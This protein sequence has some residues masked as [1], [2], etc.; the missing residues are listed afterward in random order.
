MEFMRKETSIITLVSGLLIM[1]PIGKLL[2]PL[3]LILPGLSVYI[4]VRDKVSIVELLG[5][6]ITLSILIFPVATVLAY[7]FH[8]PTSIFLGIF[9]IV[10]SIVLRKKNEKVS[11]T[12]EDEDKRVIAIAIFVALFVLFPLLSTF[13]IGE[14]GLVVSPT[15]SGDL[16]YHLSIIK[17][18][19]TST[20]IPP[21]DPYLPGHFMPY[22]W[23]MHILMGETCE[24]T[25]ISP[26]S[27]LKIVFPLLASA[28]FLNIFILTEYIFD[29]RAA[30]AS[31]VLYMFTGGFSWAYILWLHFSGSEINLFRVLIYSWSPEMLK[32][33][34]TMLFY[35]LPQTQSFALVIMIFAIYL[36]IYSIIE[37]SDKIAILA[38][39]AIGV[40]SHYHLISAFPIFLIVGSFALYKIREEGVFKV[41]TI[42]IGTAL[43]ITSFQIFAVSSGA[44]SQISIDHHPGILY[45]AVVSMGFLIPFGVIGAVKSIKVTKAR[46]ILLFAIILIIILNVLTMPLTQNTY[47]F[48]VYLTI[49]TSIFSGYFVS[50]YWDYS[51]RIRLIITLCILLLLPSTM[52]LGAYYSE[53]SYVHAD[54]NELLAMEWIKKNTSVDDI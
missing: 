19:M 31:S 54:G 42:L 22:H 11:I 23:F 13:T 30:I 16:N 14:E 32:Y 20:Q 51:T 35:L 17:R 40:L 50:M 1:L 29:K 46:G 43:I 38:G 2:I 4:L 49:P 6:S 44:G 5:A 36:S 9:L 47:R 21:E 27:L 24:M 34:S 37:R 52:I 15:H 12:M 8:L 25:G 53:V 33:D 48:L 41:S 39:F 28:L 7:L 26:F 10:I 45:T 18:Y 3:I